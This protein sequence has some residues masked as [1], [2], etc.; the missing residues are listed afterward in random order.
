MLRKAWLP[1]PTL[2]TDAVGLVAIMGGFWVGGYSVGRDIDLEDA[3]LRAEANAK[4]AQQHAEHAQLLALRTHLDPHFLFNTLNAIAEWCR[5]APEVA[6]LATLKLSEMLRSILD[7]TKHPTWSF[8]RELGLVQDLFALYAV[9][10][11]NRYVLETDV[12][13]AARNIQVP[14][15]LLLTL[16]ENAI[17]H[18]PAAGKH[19]KVFLV[20]RFDA[21]G[22]LQIHVKNPGEYTG[23]RPGGEGL[24]MI[25]RRLQHACS[26][27]ARFEIASSHGAT[28]AELYLP[29][30]EVAT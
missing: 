21:H 18:G 3:L 27:G 1:N 13:Q 25:R 4:A 6:E 11:A 12:D 14:P 15:L 9:R 28:V 24:A 23:P 19:G 20:A 17:K 5:E 26:K 10:D 16:V 22:A 30:A 29:Q 8:A 2:L 7:A